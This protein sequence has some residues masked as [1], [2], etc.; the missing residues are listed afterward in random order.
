[1]GRLV[2]GV[3]SSTQS[4]KVIIWDA[5]EKRVVRQ[6]QASHPDGTEI[7]PKHW[8]SAF[9]V[10]AQK[11]GG[12]SDVEAIS[13]GGQQHGLV[14]LNEHGGVVRP[15]ILWNDTRS[16][17]AAEDLI[18]EL[19]Q[20]TWLEATGISP[21]ASITV[22]KLRWLAE[23]EPGNAARTKAFAL[24]H[25]WLTWKISGNR[26]LSRLV[27]DRSDASGTG[28]LDLRTAEY[29]YD[30]LAHTLKISEKEAKKIILPRVCESTEIAGVVQHDDDITGLRKGTLI[31]PGCGDN[32][33][34]AL[35]LGLE[36]GEA[37]ISIGTS[38]VVSV[39]S[40]KP[41]WDKHGIVT[42]FMDA[43]G[44]WLPLACTLNGARIISQTTKLLKVGFDEFDRMALSV[45]GA[46]GMKMLPYFEGERTPNMPDAKASISGM[47]LENWKPEYLARAAVEALCDLMAGAADSIRATG[48]SLDKARLIGG[49]ANSRAVQELLPKAVGVPVAVEE[50][51]EYVAIGAAEQASMLS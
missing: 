26:D 38:G 29:R 14:A 17:R 25:D 8:L 22:T 18:V 11:A 19:G 39:V 42:T 10:A 4:C 28:Y 7:D 43:T 35:G 45:E 21:V 13:V 9:Q 41:L 44:R 33:G 23:N 20:D 6:G 36:P 16:A 50:P 51:A 5:D 15:A 47:T 32:A 27:T 34:A 40:E 2:A 31:G 48:A 37:S 12:L 24:P 3:D 46:K 30:L 49:G 1:M